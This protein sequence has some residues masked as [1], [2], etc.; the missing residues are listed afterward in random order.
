MFTEDTTAFYIAELV[1]ALSHLHLN[2][3]VVYRDLKPE[4]CLLGADG[5]LLMTDFGL[6]KVAEDGARCKSVLGTP[7]YMAPE[8]LQRKQYGFE[9]DWWS[10]G[11]LTYDLLTGSPPFRKLSHFINI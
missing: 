6:S 7:E 5:H 1:L 8:I 10:L 9:V 11:A 4:N 3:G 2:V